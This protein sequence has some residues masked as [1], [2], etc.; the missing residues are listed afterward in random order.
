MI[1][2]I[3]KV[4]IGGGL[5]TLS[6]L[7]ILLVRSGQFNFPVGIV[8]FLIFF[9]GFFY[10]LRPFRLIYSGFGELSIAIL[11][12]NLIP[13]FAYLLQY[14][15]MNRLVMIVSLPIVFLIVSL[16]LA[17]EFNSYATDIKNNRKTLLV[18]LGWENGMFLHNTF[19][20]LAFIVLGLAGVFGLPSAIV[21]PAFLPMLLALLQLWHMRQIGLGG[22]PNWRF[23]RFNAI[24]LVVLMAY[25]F[26]YTFWIR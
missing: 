16:L 24:A 20:L 21:L 13:S 17:M 7:F 5:A 18:R 15:E 22:K 9:V 4:F 23:L 11:F 14:Q 1:R 26:T 12:G 25:V 8:T 6:L 19:V 10:V 3:K 2:D